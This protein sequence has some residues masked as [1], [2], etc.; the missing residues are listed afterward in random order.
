MSKSRTV[1][2]ALAAALAL[3]VLPAAAHDQPFSSTVFFGDSLTDA[4]YFRPLLPPNVQ[5]VTGQFTTNPGLV[6]SQW[7]ADHYGT[8][9]RP[10]GNGQDGDNYAAGGATV[11]PGPG[12]PPAPPTQF[13]PSLTDQVDAYLT[14]NGGAAA[15]PFRPI[16]NGSRLPCAA[17]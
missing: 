7:L 2:T 9:A 11:V 10:N 17:S 12:F 16:H 8:G 15:P 14:A 3:A 5:A 13:A 4:G 6:W 1:R